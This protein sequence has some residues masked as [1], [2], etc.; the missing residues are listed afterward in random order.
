MTLKEIIFDQI[1]DIEAKDMGFHSWDQ[2]NTE[3]DIDQFMVAKLSVLQR[4]LDRLDSVM[5]WAMLNDY[6]LIEWGN[7]P[8]EE[9]PDL[10]WINTVTGAGPFADSQLYE[11]YKEKNP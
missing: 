9:N 3:G 1:A 11:L 8:E 7:D 6:V 4:T 5:R 10:A 2:F